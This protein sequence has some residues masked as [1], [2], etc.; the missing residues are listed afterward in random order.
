MQVEIHLADR[1]DRIIVSCDRYERKE[2][3]DDRGCLSP[4][5][6]LYRGD[7]EIGRYQAERLI[8]YHELEPAKLIF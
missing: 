1:K 7:R 8:G 4:W 6:L 2:E 5:L 3:E